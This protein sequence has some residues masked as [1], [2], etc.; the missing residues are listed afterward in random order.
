MHVTHRTMRFLRSETMGMNKQPQVYRY[1]SEVHSC[2][3]I[4]LKVCNYLPILFDDI[5]EFRSI[6]CCYAFR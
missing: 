4:G 6:A 3:Q 1:D 5:T 2:T